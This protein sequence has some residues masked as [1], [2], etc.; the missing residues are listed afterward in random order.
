MT[1]QTFT[2]TLASNGRIVIPE[3]V[4]AAMGIGDGDR[5]IGRAEN[6]ALIIEPT[7]AAVR[8]AR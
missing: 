6:G 4:R 8:R 5:V 7:V 1:G 3:S 2:L